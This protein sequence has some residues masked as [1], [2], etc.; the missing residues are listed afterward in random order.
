MKNVLA[1]KMIPSSP[2]RMERTDFD[3]DMKN[4]ESS[5]IESISDQ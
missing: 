2:N 3:V 1:L 4:E 5:F